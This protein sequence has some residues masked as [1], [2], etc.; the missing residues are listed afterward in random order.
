MKN[1]V[2]VVDFALPPLPKKKKK[3]NLPWKSLDLCNRISGSDAP[4]PFP[5]PPLYLHAGRKNKMISYPK[6]LCASRGGCFFLPGEAEVWS[7]LSAVFMSCWL[8]ECVCVCFVSGMH[9][10]G[11]SQRNKTSPPI[12]PSASGRMCLMAGLLQKKL[13]SQGPQKQH[14]ASTW[15]EGVGSVCVCVCVVFG[16]QTPVW[17]CERVSQ[18]LF[19]NPL[20]DLKAF[21]S[22][23]ID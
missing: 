11:E 8:C 10:V 18:L 9:M 1:A 23:L 6:S 12:P 14:G 5:Q 4:P 17:S 22:L 20:K 15:Q 16:D 13:S 7:Q 3:K 2:E 21:H 19:T